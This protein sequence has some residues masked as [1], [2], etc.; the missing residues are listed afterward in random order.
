MQL[1]RKVISIL[2][3]LGVGIT[4]TPNL[5]TL[6]KKS[7]QLNDVASKIQIFEAFFGFA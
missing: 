2:A 4:S 5:I 6:F 3:S 7:E 1:G